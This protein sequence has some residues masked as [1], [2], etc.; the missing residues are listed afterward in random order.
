VGGGEGLGRSTR[1]PEEEA[2]WVNRAT[3]ASG[4]SRCAGRKSGV[5]A[6]LIREEGAR[7]PVRR[8][9]ARALGGCGARR[10]GK[11][12]MSALRASEGF[13]VRRR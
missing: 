3:K 13:D 9:G 11:A 2:V 6:S 10:G 1:V 5:L 4:G 12:H 7:P 8:L